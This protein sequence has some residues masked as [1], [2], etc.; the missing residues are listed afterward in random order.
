M[1]AKYKNGEIV[2][3]LNYKGINYDKVFATKAEMDE[4]F[5]TVIESK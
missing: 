4:W 3:K 5:K 2:V 1:A